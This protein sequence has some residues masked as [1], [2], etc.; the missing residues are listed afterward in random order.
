MDRC[1]FLSRGPVSTRVLSCIALRHPRA[2]SFHPLRYASTPLTLALPSHC[3]GLRRPLP[4]CSTRKR[5]LSWIQNG[6]TSSA[7]PCARHTWQRARR[8][9][10]A[11]ELASLTTFLSS[12]RTTSPGCNFQVL[13]GMDSKFIPLIE[14]GGG[15]VATNLRALLQKG[16]EGDFQTCNHG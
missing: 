5:L 12:R 3:Q 1:P 16:T 10:Q 2:R 6:S 15:I 4:F 14:P 9:S 7:R 13:S 8:Y 11:E